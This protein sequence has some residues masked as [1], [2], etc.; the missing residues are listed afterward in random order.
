M[1]PLVRARRGVT[2]RSLRWRGRP[3]AL[4]PRLAARL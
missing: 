1:L 2:S 3:A 4:R